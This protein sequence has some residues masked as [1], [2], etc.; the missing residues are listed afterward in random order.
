MRFEVQILG[1][2]LRLADNLEDAYSEDCSAPKGWAPMDAINGL[3]VKLWGRG[4]LF[5]N[6]EIRGPR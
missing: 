3:L 6:G 2:V 4:L 1:S 5:E